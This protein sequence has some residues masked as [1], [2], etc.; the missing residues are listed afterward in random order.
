MRITGSRPCIAIT[1]VRTDSPG[2]RHRHAFTPHAMPCWL[3]AL[4]RC[5]REYKRIERASKTGA[6]RR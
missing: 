1:E 3:P 6:F 5:T 2:G 4:S